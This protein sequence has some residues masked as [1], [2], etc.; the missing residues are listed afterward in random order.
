MLKTKAVAPLELSAS[1]TGPLLERL[2]D[3]LVQQVVGRLQADCSPYHWRNLATASRR[4]C[5]LVG[6]V[7]SSM[8][9]LPQVSVAQTVPGAS[10]GPVDPW[11]ANNTA[12]HFAPS[13]HHVSR[14][15]T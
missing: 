10:S 8:R 4:L 7:W 14:V 1:D 6:G 11:E 13:M 5:T 12:T 15:T 9:T 2:D 3:E